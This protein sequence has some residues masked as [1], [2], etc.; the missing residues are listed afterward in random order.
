MTCLAYCPSSFHDQVQE[1][2]ARFV[3]RR[4]VRIDF[5]LFV[6][7]KVGTFGPSKMVH[8]S[9]IADIM[10]HGQKNELRCCF[11]NLCRQEVPCFVPC[12]C[13]YLRMYRLKDCHMTA[14]HTN[15]HH[16]HRRNTMHGCKHRRADEGRNDNACTHSF[17]R[18]RAH[19]QTQQYSDARTH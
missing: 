18:A 1:L 19:T 9:A 17:A 15:T 16:T 14:Q 8:A 12:K 4:I 11:A 5:A 7:C 6:R 13:K 10:R 3:W 2:G